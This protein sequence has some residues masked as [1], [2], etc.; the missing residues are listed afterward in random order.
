MTNDY[1]YAW[2]FISFLALEILSFNSS[3]CLKCQIGLLLSLNKEILFSTNIL[4]WSIYVD[5]L[6]NLEEHIYLS[7]KGYYELKPN[8]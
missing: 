6:M 2:H 3:R 7:W 5:I 8:G 4:T 1:K